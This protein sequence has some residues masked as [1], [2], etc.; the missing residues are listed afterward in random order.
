MIR[1]VMAQPHSRQI[2]C[3]SGSDNRP[4]V[5]WVLQPISIYTQDA[6]LPKYLRLVPLRLLDNGQNPL[7]HLH[8]CQFF[9]G[10]IRAHELLRL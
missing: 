8:I 10:R 1:R 6:R 3:G 9:K 5:R 4:H 7:R 2:Q